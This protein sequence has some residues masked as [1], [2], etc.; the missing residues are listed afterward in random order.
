MRNKSEARAHASSVETAPRRP[1]SRR[2]GPT[3]C[4]PHCYAGASARKR[5]SGTMLGTFPSKFSRVSLPGL[6]NDQQRHEQRQ[7]QEREIAAVNNGSGGKRRH[8]EGRR[9]MRRQES[10]ERIC[11]AHEKISYFA[12]S[13]GAITV[14]RD[15]D[16]Q[17]RNARRCF[18]I[19]V[20]LH[21]PSRVTTTLWLLRHKM[22]PPA[23]PQPPPP[24]WPQPPPSTRKEPRFPIFP[25]PP[26]SPSVPL[27]SPPHPSSSDTTT[28]KVCFFY[29]LGP[30]LLDIF[31][32][33]MAR[34]MYVCV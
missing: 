8:G 6:L 14:G 24:R 13:E 17:R 28:V 30:S 16:L 1:L 4:A 3:R 11:S 7:Q 20:A 34:R 5:S 26:R 10:V 2:A 25:F 12:V 29:A 9:V 33:P 23:P 22:P 32:S 31:I 27:P 18:L 21:Q 15:G 19:P